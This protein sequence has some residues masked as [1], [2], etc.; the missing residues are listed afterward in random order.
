MN[1]ADPGEEEAHERRSSSSRVG[2]HTPNSATNGA[3]IGP[4]GGGL[5]SMMPPLSKPTGPRYGA[6]AGMIV[7]YVL[8]GILNAVVL[9][10]LPTMFA[11]PDYALAV[12]AIIAL[13]VI[14]VVYMAKRR[15]IPAKYLLP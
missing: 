5:A 15:F 11:K 6:S 9:A 13:I 12:S 4:E 7:K 2:T 10:S 8:L 3:T 1:T 14:D